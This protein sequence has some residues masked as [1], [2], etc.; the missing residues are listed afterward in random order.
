MS[1]LASLVLHH[2][3]GAPSTQRTRS[4][5]LRVAGQGG[6]HPTPQRASG[7]RSCCYGHRA[8]GFCRF[9]T[10]CH[11]C[12]PLGGSPGSTFR[13]QNMCFAAVA[14]LGGRNQWSISAELLSAHI[15]GPTGAVRCDILAVFISQTEV[16]LPTPPTRGVWGPRA[17]AAVGDLTLQALGVE[18]SSLCSLRFQEH[19][20]HGSTPSPLSWGLMSLH[21]RPERLGAGRERERDCIGQK[22]SRRGET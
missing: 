16:P 18:E 5:E 22:A 20:S 11:G 17:C 10:Y 2:K 6:I 9:L 7:P 13:V 12:G 8:S 1:F 14:A 3:G 4:Q 15:R 19:P 21:T